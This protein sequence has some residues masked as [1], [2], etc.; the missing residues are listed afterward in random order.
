MLLVGE[1][2]RVGNTSDV[3]RISQIFGIEVVDPANAAAGF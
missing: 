1:D 2:S 3:L